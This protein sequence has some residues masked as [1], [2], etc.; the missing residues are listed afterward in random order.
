LRGAGQKRDC[1]Q[2]QCQQGGV[3]HRGCPCGD[4]SVNC[5]AKIVFLSNLQTDCFIEIK[6]HDVQIY[7]I[8]ARKIGVSTN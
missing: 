4:F 2:Q 5:A 8:F 6:F 1:E 3:S 7:C